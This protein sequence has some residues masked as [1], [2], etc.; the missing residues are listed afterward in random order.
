MIVEK[1]V[2]YSIKNLILNST[3]GN[4]ITITNEF[5]SDG[6]VRFDDRPV[7]ILEF[8]VKRDFSKESTIAQVLCQ[9]MCYYYRLVQKDKNSI[10]YTKPFYLIIGDENEISLI[11]IHKI[12]NNWLMNEKWGTVA[13]SSASKEPDLMKIVSSVTEIVTPIYYNYSD[14]NELAFGF[15]ILF[16]NK[17]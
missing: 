7:A 15:Y 13:P 3:E 10:D 5:R 17:I 6:I 8:K 11:N 14:I 16:S 9:A 2:E 12:P 4:F 1:D